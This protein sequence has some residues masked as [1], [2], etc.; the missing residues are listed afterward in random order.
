MAIIGII[1]NKKNPPFSI[2][3]FVFWMPQFKKFLNTTDGQKYFDKLYKL[4]DNK[5]FYSIYGNDWELAMSYAIAHYLTL[6]SN[7]E[8]NPSGDTLAGI[9]GGGVHKG[10]LSSAG[11]GGFN[12]QFDLSKTIYDADEALFWNQTSYGGSLMALLKTKA[13]PSIM[14]VTSNPVPGAN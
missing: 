9:A 11:V 6:I 12:K 1:T 3:D 14:V 8:G 10:I 4:V 13:I 7:Q 2:D 5:I